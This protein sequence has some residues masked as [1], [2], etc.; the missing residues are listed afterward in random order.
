MQEI[1]FGLVERRS[2]GNGER[3]PLEKMIAR[4]SPRALKSARRGSFLITQECD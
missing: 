1:R 2:E 3:V 4:R